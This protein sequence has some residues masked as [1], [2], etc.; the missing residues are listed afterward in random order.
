MRQLT[1]GFWISQAIYVVARLGI[2]DLL[3][4]GPR[5]VEQLAEA[6]ATHA[7]SLHRLL[8]ALASNGIFTETQPQTFALT[9]LADTLRGDVPGS[10]RAAAMMLGEEHYQTWVDL[11]YSIQTGQVAFDH[12]YGKGV[13]DYFAENPR[14][15]EIFDATMT[16]VHGAETAAMLDAYDFSRFG[17][18]I[19]IGGG[20]GTLL[21]EVLKRTTSLKAVLFDRPH[22]VARAAPNLAAAGLASRCSTTDGDFFVSVPAGGD[23]YLLRHII[24]DWDDERSRTILRN[25]RKVLPSKGVVLVVESVI[26]PGNEPFFG[27]WLDLN[28]LVIPGGKERTADEYRMLF[29]ECGLQLQRIVPTR[30]EVSVIEATPV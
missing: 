13:F 30:M 19:D 6:T 4:D 5:T 14:A 9:P 11:F 29:A 25:V 7:Q 26:P 27:K 18:L 15:A 28:M 3:R 2:A 23:A 17:T 24:H 21:I 20:N 1:T 10:Q 8:R 22:V 12:R 16:A